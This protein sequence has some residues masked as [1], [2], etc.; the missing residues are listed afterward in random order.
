MDFTLDQLLT[1]VGRLDDGPGFDTSRERFRRFLVDR[2]GALDSAR[3]I[4]EQCRERSGEQSHRALQDAVVLFGRFLGFETNF[5]RYH[6]EPGAVP[7]HGTWLSRH[8][9]QVT[10]I[11]C[12]DQTADLDLDS[13]SHRI[14]DGDGDTLR[15]A[16]LVVT[17]FYAGRDRLEHAVGAGQHP[18]L[19]LI[20]LRGMIRFAGLVT[21]GQLTH[22]DVLQ[23]FTPPV[24]LDGRIDLLERVAAAARSEPI[25]EDLSASIL[26]PERED[27]RY[28]VN[29][30]GVDPFTPTERIVRSLIGTR[31]ILG[32]NPAPGLEDRVR[33]GDAICVFVAGRGIVAHAQIAGILM[34]GSRIIRDAKRFTHV[35]RLTNVI[36]YDTPVLPN[37]DLTRKLDLALA[38]DAEAVTAPISPRE[39]ESITA[40][41]LSEAG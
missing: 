22:H 41:A 14:S 17:P 8:R 13:V 27:R 36:V 15:I 40:H 4:L 11:V 2:M 19:R 28:W 10:L 30:M 37:P 31:Q 7:A 18:N 20:S 35:L 34:D 38:D 33:T 39:F 24:T 12:T 21:E 25:G 32:I 29:V 26:E 23:V 5:G 1:I 16:L 9:L 3:L 6:H